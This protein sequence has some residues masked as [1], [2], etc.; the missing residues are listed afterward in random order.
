MISIKNINISGLDDFIRS[1]EYMA[2]KNIPVS[3]QRAISQINNPRA[4]KNDVVLFLAYKEDEFIGYLGALPDYIYSGKERFKIAWLSCMWVDKRYRRSGIAYRLMN[5]AN[6]VWNSNLLI[7]N[8]IPQSKA[9][10]DKTDSYTDFITLY[11]IRGYLRFDLAGILSSRKKIFKRI[12]FLLSFSDLILNIFNELRLILWK[13][14]RAKSTYKIE[15]LNEI[16]NETDEFIRKHNADSL[17][18]KQKKEFDWMIKYPWIKEGKPDHNSKKYEFSS[19]AKRFGYMNMKVFNEDD[20]LIAF[21]ILTRNNSF[22][23]T[24]FLFFDIEN[25][26]IVNNVITDI[27]LSLKIKTITTYNKNLAEFIFKRSYPYI[28]TKKMEY[29]SIITKKLSERIKISKDVVFFEGD[30]DG[31][32]T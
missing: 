29:H 31:A 2:L 19:V 30:G 27:A 4:D 11:G 13:M 1:D 28:K 10:F 24:P 5:H 21:C 8:F 26:K 25:V 17:T 23:K 12:K 14:F 15:Y 18:G 16:D 9:V 20:Q 3:R 6:E 22:L 32:F 7:S